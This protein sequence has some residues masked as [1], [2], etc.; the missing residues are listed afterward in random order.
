M[1]AVLVLEGK[2]DEL[3]DDLRRQMEQAAEELR[4]ERAAELRDRLK[5]VE[6]LEHKRRVI[7]TAFADTDAVG[8]CRGA[9]SCF[10]VLHFVGGDL[11]GKDVEM[12]DEPLEDDSEAVSGLCANISRRTAAAGRSRSCSRVRSTIMTA[13]RSC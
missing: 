12:F 3:V 10:V 11:V 4:F 2:S 6:L 9:K 1:Q 5:A 13:W 8:F 7:S